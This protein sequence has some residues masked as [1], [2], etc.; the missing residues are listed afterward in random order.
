MGKKLSPL[1][2]GFLGI[3]LLIAIS[4]TVFFGY[5]YLQYRKIPSGLAQESLPIAISITNPGSGHIATAGTPQSITIM[6]SGPAP[7]LA[8]ELWADN[9]LVGVQAAPTTDGVM[10]FQASFSWLSFK[11]GAHILRARA[12]DVEEQ[13]AESEV[14]WIYI[15]EGLDPE[16]DTHIQL[17]NPQ[18]P[19][20]PSPP[21]SAEPLG[22]AISWAPSLGSFV[23]WIIPNDNPPAAPELVGQVEGCS[24][25]LMIHDLSENELGF[26]VF[27]TPDGKS[28]NPVPT[29]VLGPHAGQGWFETEDAPMQSGVYSYVVEAFVDQGVSALSNPILVNV[30]SEDCP[31]QEDEPTPYYLKLT[32]FKPPT[33]AENLYCYVS[34]GGGVWQR[35]PAIGFFP[36]SVIEG[37]EPSQGS[38]Q[39]PAPES[40]D[41]NEGG[42]SFPVDSFF[43]VTMDLSLT[44]PGNSKDSDTIYWDCWGWVAGHVSPQGKFQ[45]AVDT[46]QKGMIKLNDSALSA[47]I[48]FE[49]GP[50]DYLE[51]FF[52]P[53]PTYD[54]QLL[55]PT[56]H[57]STETSDCTNRLPGTIKPDFKI[58][59]C[60]PGDYVDI[61]DP[62]DLTLHPHAYLFW[63]LDNKINCGS[64]GYCVDPSDPSSLDQWGYFVAEAGYNLYDLQVSDLVPAKTFY[65]LNDILYIVPK[66]ES[67]G[68][69]R[70]FKIRTFVKLFGSEIIFESKGLGTVLSFVEPCG[71]INLVIATPEVIEIEIITPE[72]IEAELATQEVIYSEIVTP[73][74][75]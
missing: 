74:T 12:N 46:L 37:F 30:N 24:V 49:L 38:T 18:T 31:P 50:L 62:G 34:Q 59:M 43:D 52:P 3:I 8:I 68:D 36:A 55:A 21:S 2:V 16:G 28:Q 61:N 4:F 23:K 42:S 69:V 22:Q 47:E 11:P 1:R 14:V 40:I 13:V 67:C 35:I 17:S 6:A 54:P 41:L 9:E 26:S 64:P 5:K 71:M 44:G 33:P 63:D 58:P 72:V 65:S 29:F 32:N 56:I 57:F 75:P 51:A 45:V 53:K 20:P 60:H 66:D 27:R 19:S 70:T 25:R 10:P 15:G 48:N 73:E 39:P 7:L